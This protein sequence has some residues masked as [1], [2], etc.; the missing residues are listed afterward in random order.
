MAKLSFMVQNLNKQ[1]Q[2]RVLG[3]MSGTSIDGLDLCLVDFHWD[4]SWNFKILTCNTIPYS[5]E[6]EQKLHF[7]KL[8]EQDLTKL[9]SDYG[10]LLG[11]SVNQFLEKNKIDGQ[12]IDFIASHGHTWYHQPAE[13]I[14]LQIG[15]GP[16]LYRETGIP[17]ICDF[18]KADVELGGQGAP[19]VP[20]GDRDLFSD[21]DACLNLGGFANISF[22]SQESRIAFDIAPCNLP[23][24]YYCQK[25][26]LPFD[27]EGYIAASHNS[28]TKLLNHLNQIDYY[29]QPAPKSLGVEWL[30]ENILSLLD[31]S[32][33]S[34][35]TLIATIT[36]HSAYQIAQNLNK[37]A[38]KRV[39]L[40]GGGTKNQCLI[41]S[42]GIYTNC[43]LI[44]ADEPLN[45]FKEALIF[46]YL[47]LLRRLNQNNILASVTGAPYDHSSGVLYP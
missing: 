33:E 25:L 44:I 16:E 26:G 20:I 29:Q 35:E 9:D 15:N 22:D 7:K 32:G 10:Q 1:N 4:D 36:K 30:Q 19:L 5:A 28:K 8:P 2:F 14:S 41:D 6:W 18:R 40:S 11:S 34:P 39:L 45:S 13:G 46:A 24:N 37:Y 17:V 38:V 23:I 21:F 31:S 42:I 12:S 3:L 43:E 47:G 27:D